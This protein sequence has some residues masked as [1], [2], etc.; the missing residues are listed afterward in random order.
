M[1]RPD[2]RDVQRAFAAHLRDPAANAAPAGLDARR[3]QVYRDVLYHNIESF[4]A[5]F[6]PVLRSLYDETPWHALVRDFFARHRA[7]SPYFLDIA[8]EFLH[9]L[10][11]ARG[12][13]AGDPP[14]LRALAH[15][16]WLE[17]VVDVDVATLPTGGVDPDGD[18]L[19]GVPYP[20]PLAV[21]ATYDWPV[22]R[23]SREYRPVSPSPVPVC[24]MVYRD[25]A[26]RVRFLELNPAA[27]R[28]WGLLREQPMA[29]GREL[30]A[31]A[32]AELGQDEG[33]VAE[34]AAAL[35]ATLRARDIVLGTRL[36]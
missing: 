33:A 23:I 10:D 8:E 34:G 30:A 36:R 5:G 28:L 12:E 26:D 21:L 19:A 1:T 15:Y 13:V 3:L 16:E 14:F 17:L 7:R 24:L 27:A 20:S 32:S 6:F 2:F 35:L 22:H 18:L 4:L 31:L 29:T 11:T 9:Y 25:R